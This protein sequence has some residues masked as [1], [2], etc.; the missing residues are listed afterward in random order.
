MDRGG[1]LI[2]GEPG[3]EAAVV[4]V[5]WIVPAVGAGRQLGRIVVVG[6]SID[7]FFAALLG[8]LAEGDALVTLAEKSADK[9]ADKR[10]AA[11]RARGEAD[12]LDL[13]TLLGEPVFDLFA[14]VVAGLLRGGRMIQPRRTA[15]TIGFRWCAASSGTAHGRDARATLLFELVELSAGLQ[16]DLEAL[17]VWRESALGRF[18]DVFAAARAFL[19]GDGFL[20]LLEM[21]H[22]MASDGVEALGFETVLQLLARGG[23]ARSGFVAGRLITVLKPPLNTAHDLRDAALGEAVFF[24]QVALVQA[25]RLVIEINLLI[26]LAGSRALARLA[27]TGREWRFACH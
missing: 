13:I 14:A 24:G 20:L 26:A 21:L 3:D 23:V 22:G 16:D 11:E 4:V 2:G 6:F 19:V 5:Q 1:E 25:G 7:D 18:V 8:Q 27:E 12:A 10:P 9:V 15:A 17:D